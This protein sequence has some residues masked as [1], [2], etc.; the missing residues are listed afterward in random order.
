MSSCK[1]N[2]NP[3]ICSV[4]HYPILMEIEKVEILTITGK[5]SVC[6]LCYWSFKVLSLVAFMFFFICLRSF[7]GTF[8]S[9]KIRWWFGIFQLIVLHYNRLVFLTMFNLLKSWLSM[10]DHRRFIIA[11]HEN[12]EWNFLIVSNLLVEYLYTNLHKIHHH[13]VSVFYIKLFIME[14]N[15]LILMIV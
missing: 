6:V 14:F 5:I 3:S 11:G 13:L 7:F 10:L 15:D 1:Q 2:F 8:K 9:C 12:V 4:Y